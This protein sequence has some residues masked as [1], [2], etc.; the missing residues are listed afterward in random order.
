MSSKTLL[1]LAILLLTSAACTHRVEPRRS[2]FITPAGAGQPTPLE[3]P[4]GE[5]AAAPS[6]SLGADSPTMQALRDLQAARG[7]AVAAPKSHGTAASAAVEAGR[8]LVAADPS[9]LEA[10]LALAR[11]YHHER[12]FDLA[13]EHYV[14]ARELAPA[15]PAI[16][17]DLGR[18]W[19]DEGSPELALPYLERA[20]AA[21]EADAE[22]WSYRGIALDLL[23][24][25]PEAEGAFRRSIELESRRWDFFNNLGFNLLLQERHPEAAAAFR[26]GLVLAPGHPVLQNNLG[27]ALGL[28]GETAAALEAF[29]RGG[30]EADAWNNL[31]VVHRARREDDLAAQAFERAFRLDAGSRSIARNVRESRLRAAIARED[32]T[33]ET[34]DAAGAGMAVAVLAP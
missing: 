29:R 19:V 23:S 8:A 27:L 26:S 20:L 12:I 22:T 33:A 13:L 5:A 34:A 6:D 10:R 9:S 32:A 16:D 7:G 17:R 3:L 28:Q 30:S 2:P 11:A 14:A 24:R 1:L 18:L 21:L 31:G 4:D 15:D 25:Y